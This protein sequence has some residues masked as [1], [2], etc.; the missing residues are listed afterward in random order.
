M[1]NWFNGIVGVTSTAGSLAVA[2]WQE[3]LE[4]WTRYGIMVAG[5]IITLITVLNGLEA[6]KE[7]RWFKAIRNWRRG[8]K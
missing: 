3:H 2:A 6:A 4:F 5:G 1:K 7:K 8:Q